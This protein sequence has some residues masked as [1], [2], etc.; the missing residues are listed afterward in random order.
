MTID[1]SLIKET[2]A[3]LFDCVSSPLWLD[4][5]VDGVEFVGNTYHHTWPFVSVMFSSEMDNNKKKRVVRKAISI[6]R[7]MFLKEHNSRL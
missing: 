6:A 1:R 5:Q 4:A 7:D 3:K 2:E